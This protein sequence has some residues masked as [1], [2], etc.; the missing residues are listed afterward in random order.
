MSQ[1]RVR[2]IETLILVHVFRQDEIKNVATMT[3]LRLHKRA[4]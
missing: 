4:I 3:S 2:A 1:W